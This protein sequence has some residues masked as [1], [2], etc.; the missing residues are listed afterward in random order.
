L[1]G[2]GDHLVLLF[3]DRLV[4]LRVGRM[5]EIGEGLM[6]DETLIEG[7]MMIDEGI[8][9]LVEIEIPE[10]DRACRLGAGYVLPLSLKNDADK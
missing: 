4:L 5:I 2:I 8:I 6:I 10:I 1:T 9:R 7:G 3:V